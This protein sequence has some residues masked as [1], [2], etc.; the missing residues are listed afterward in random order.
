MLTMSTT[1]TQDTASNTE[2]TNSNQLQNVGFGLNLVEIGLSGGIFLILQFLL[3]KLIKLFED[4]DKINEITIQKIIDKCENFEKNN[5]SAINAKK[6]IKEIKLEAEE[7]KKTSNE[8]T[9]KIHDD[10]L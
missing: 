3:K 4:K 8:E 2:T 1:N 6:I 10:P 5:Y 7:C 9:K